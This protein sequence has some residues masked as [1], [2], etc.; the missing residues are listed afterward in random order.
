MARGQRAVR[1][2]KNRQPVDVWCDFSV[3]APRIIY[4]RHRP[5]QM[6]QEAVCSNVKDKVDTRDRR[7]PTRAPWQLPAGCWGSASGGC[8]NRGDGPPCHSR[9]QMNCRNPVHL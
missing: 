3:C 6:A 5:W 7:A 1:I 4:Y 2:G 8:G 9:R